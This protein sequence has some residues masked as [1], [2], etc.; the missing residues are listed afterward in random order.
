[1]KTR[2]S[3]P[4]IWLIAILLIPP[5]ARES[6]GAETRKTVE[7][8]QGTRARV[9]DI[10]QRDGEMRRL[11]SMP[12][13]VEAPL[14]AASEP[15]RLDAETNPALAMETADP[16]TRLRT[17]GSESPRVVEPVKAEIADAPQAD[18][19]SLLDLMRLTKGASSIELGREIERRIGWDERVD[20]LGEDVPV[21]T[22]RGGIALSGLRDFRSDRAASRAVPAP[23]RS[24]GREVVLHSKGGGAIL[25]LFL[26][27]GLGGGRASGLMDLAGMALLVCLLGMFGTLVWGFHDAV[28]KKLKKPTLW[29]SIALWPA[30][31]LAISA[32][33]AG[34]GTYIW[35]A[36]TTWVGP[37][38][39]L[40]IAA[41]LIGAAIG[42]PTT[43][44]WR[45]LLGK[46][47]NP[48]LAAK[49]ALWPGAMILLFAAAAAALTPIVI[50]YHVPAWLWSDLSPYSDAPMFF[51]FLGFLME[52]AVFF[53]VSEI[54]ERKTGRF[55]IG[56]R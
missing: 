7:E 40:A 10:S 14:D 37:A 4:L 15:V 8:T 29:K 55:L 13:G 51:A 27:M 50:G 54:Y 47:E 45:Y 28:Y 16:Q 19:G 18:R 52:A 20:S 23:N 21:A 56:S 48:S 32:L 1:M 39:F 53:I 25:F 11:D 22:P 5:A 35:L 44:L 6:F 30:G 24:P 49:I 46:M 12:E 41:A 3:L 9:A 31:V 17:L 2:V 38:T 33:F 26:I 42:L 34:F 36:E 43:K